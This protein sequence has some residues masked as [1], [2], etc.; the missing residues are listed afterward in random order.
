MES[1]LKLKKTGEVRVRIAPS[2]TGPL[3]IGTARA[4]LF[5]YLFATKN[6]GRFILRIEDTDIKRSEKKWEKS[7][8]DGLKWLGLN[9]SEGPDIDG[10]YAPYRQSQRSKIYYKYLKKLLDEN[11]AYYCF[12]SEE[13]LKAHREYLMSIGRPPIYSGKCAGLSDGEI[14]DNFKKGKPAIIRFKMPSEKVKF[15]DLIRGEVE[16]DSKLIGDPVIAKNINGLLKPINKAKKQIREIS[17]LY[18]FAV[19]VDDYEMKISHVIRGEDHISN[20]PKQILIQ[21]DLGFPQPKYAHLPLVLGPDR[22]KLSKRHGVVSVTDYKKEGYLP[23]AIINFMALLGWNPGN[24]REIFSLN[25]LIKDFSLDNVQKSGAVFNIEKLTSINGFY[26]RKKSLEKLTKLCLS[27][28]I[29]EKLVE[30]VFEDE[31]KNKYKQAEMEGK[32]AAQKYKIPATKEEVSFDYLKNIIGAYQERLK[33]LS[34]ITELVDCFFKDKLNYPKD[35]L[36]WKDMTNKELKTSLDKLDNILSKIEREEWEFE[37][38][39]DILMKK[40]EEIEFRGKKNRGFLLWPL[41]ASLTG[42][43]ASAG[44]FEV[45]SILGKEKT[46]KRIKQARETIND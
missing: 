31:M 15:K 35:L 29:K 1:E 27:Y 9:W 7:I 17:F 40:S 11:K 2:P 34:E 42:K 21:K 36:K 33:K 20:T 22:S 5:N 26:I 44:P 10:D 16:F 13:E 18:N 32:L 28:L 23:S 19:V 12:C 4:A 45:A 46:L 37:N 38:L 30:P 43:K 25:S 3:H 14:K 24:D 39:K 41:R 8:I 6:Q